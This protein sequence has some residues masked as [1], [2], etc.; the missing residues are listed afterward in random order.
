MIVLFGALSF[1]SNRVVRHLGS[2]SVVV[3]KTCRS[4]SVRDPNSFA[5]CESRS[6]EEDNVPHRTCFQRRLPGVSCS[7]GPHLI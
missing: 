7:F 3:A 6:D 4:H 2:F 1:G 5:A